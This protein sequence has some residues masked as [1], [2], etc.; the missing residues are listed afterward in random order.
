MNNNNMLSTTLLN[1]FLNNTLL[2]LEIYLIKEELGIGNGAL[3]IGD[4]ALVIGN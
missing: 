4:W 2:N 3:G 1:P